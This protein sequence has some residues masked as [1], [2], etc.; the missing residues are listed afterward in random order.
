MLRL[1][2][3]IPVETD[4][5]ENPTPYDTGLQ[6]DLE[7]FGPEAL[8]EYGKLV[9]RNILPE[10]RWNAALW[11]CMKWGL[12]HDRVGDDLVITDPQA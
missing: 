2:E 12:N 7:E 4:A 6:A 1:A 10:P 9:V 11:Y 3:D 8:Q 5:P